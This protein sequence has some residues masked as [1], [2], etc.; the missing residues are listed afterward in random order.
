[1][2]VVFPEGLEEPL[3]LVSKPNENGVLDTSVVL[4][5]KA[6]GDKFIYGVNSA[7]ESSGSQV[8]LS[9]ALDREDLV[10]KVIV[11]VRSKDVAPPLTVSAPITISIA[12]E[13]CVQYLERQAVLERGVKRGF[14]YEPEDPDYRCR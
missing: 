4:E 5:V 1:M 3:H 12:E 13:A 2:V 10:T 8:S 7:G 9:R 14:T 11:R 6:F